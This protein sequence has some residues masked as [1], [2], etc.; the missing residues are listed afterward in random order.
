MPQTTILRDNLSRVALNFDFRY[1]NWFYQNVVLPFNM[2][3]QTQSNWCWAAT[4]KSVSHFYSGLSPWTQCKIA[5]KELTQTCCTSPVP[6]ACNV[7]WYLNKALDRTFN[8]VSMQSGT[9]SWS[10]IKSQLDQGLVVGTR[11]G[12]NGGGGHFMVIYGVSRVFHNEYLYIDDPIYG[13][14]VLSY[15]EF[16]TNY[17]G[18]GS[19]THTYFTKKHYYF[20]WLK[21]LQFNPRLLSPIPEVR[22]FARFN[23]PKFNVTQE[24]P[25]PEYSTAHHT[26][27][28]GLNEISP[29]SRF[30]ERPVSL[31]VMEFEDSAAVAMYEVGL[32]EEQPQFM[33]L[34][35]NKEY[36]TNFEN[37][38]NRLKREGNEDYP[39]ELRAI[40]VP[41]L[42]LE[43]VW[44]H[45]DDPQ[46]DKF[47]LV[48][49][50]GEDGRKVFNQ[51]EFMEYLNRQKA[52]MGQMDE[53]MG[54]GG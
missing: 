51:A 26:Y 17:Q 37:A 11:I 6:S 15:N 28:I 49:Q 22:P 50:F 16:A 38:L 40:R 23:N 1:Y 35:V 7:P 20:M 52:Q 39:G 31:R 21:D 9:I 24:I 53:L 43:A 33:Q 10:E 12:W 27:V 29:E 42:N 25:E 2:E 54:A 18:A 44:V 3:A 30:P 47:V 48:R 5:G 32:N 4:A 8:Y 19:W 13:K 45:Y 14:S 34:N 41:A 36:F 46:H